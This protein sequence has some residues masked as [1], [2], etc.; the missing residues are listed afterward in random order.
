[1][2]EMQVQSPGEGNGN[3]FQDSGKSHV[4]RSLAGYSP[5]DCNS[6]TLFSDWT[7][8]A[9]LGVLLMRKCF[10][11]KSSFWQL[12][13]RRNSLPVLIN[14]PPLLSCMKRQK[15]RTPQVLK[16][17][18]PRSVGAQWRNNS[19][20]NEGMEPKQKQHPVVDVTGDRSKVWCCKEQY[21]IGTWSWERLKAGGE[22]DNRGWDG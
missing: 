16:D 19:R 21:C 7:T 4:Q 3:P 18:L 20:K 13:L 1:M 2:Q 15:D 10:K 9:E 6:W 14:A 5:H 11:E 8:T 12:S 17:Q 22:G